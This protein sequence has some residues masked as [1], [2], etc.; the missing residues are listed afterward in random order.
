MNTTSTPRRTVRALLTGVIAAA[1]AAGVVACGD[2]A[3][4]Q[5]D[6]TLFVVATATANEP[7]PVLPDSLSGVLK[8][9]VETGEGSLTVLVP[10]EDG[11]IES[12]GDPIDIVVKRGDDVENDAAE[13]AKGLVPIRAAVDERLASAASNSTSLDLLSGLSYAARRTGDSTIVAVSSGLQTEGLA[14]FAGL[15]WEFDNAEVI[16]RLADAGFIPDLSGRRVYFSGLGAVAGAQ[17]ALPEPMIRKVTSFWLDL[18]EAAEANSCEAVAGPAKAGVAASKTPAKVVA[19]PVFALP[20]L[21]NSADE[22]TLDSQ[23]LFGPDSA[24][25]RPEAVSQMGTLAAHL[26]KQRKPI[27]ITGH[28][29]KWGPADGARDLSQRR[30]QTIADALTGSGLRPQLIKQVRGVGYD[31]LITLAGA[32]EEA[33]AAANRVVVIDL[34][35]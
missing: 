3:E 4:L 12:A 21:D 24:E 26:N 1:L 28:A 31:Q 33:T 15:G 8:T 29:W 20:P 34:A 17:P 30:A 25:M 9:A 35:R 5:R 32:D 23:A 13:I 11:T 19:V 27:T 6:G 10:K 14:D 16:A 18:C 22:L 2:S 7:L